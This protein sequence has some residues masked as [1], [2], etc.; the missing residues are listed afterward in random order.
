MC[1]CACGSLGWARLAG[2]M[3][4]R[5]GLSQWLHRRLGNGTGR[6]RGSDGRVGG[7]PSNVCVN[8]P[9]CCG[10]LLGG[11]WVGWGMAASRGL[12]RR[13][14]APV[15][16]P[17]LS[18]CETER[19]CV[20]GCVRIAF[21]GSRARCARQVQLRRRDRVRDRCGP[22]STSRPLQ[23][24]TSARPTSAPSTPPQDGPHPLIPRLRRLGLRHLQWTALRHR[25]RQQDRH[26]QCGRPR[27]QR[28]Q[29]RCRGRMQGGVDRG[30][31]PRSLASFCGVM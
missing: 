26:W 8:V 22:S 1:V 12:A 15:R 4:G 31:T 19:A 2:G 27:Q 16:S 17:A 3:R 18:P 30:T 5:R 6:S 7:K 11:C 21:G 20:A 24:R 10:S 29:W 14:R 9:V 13:S 25:H 23:G 28:Q